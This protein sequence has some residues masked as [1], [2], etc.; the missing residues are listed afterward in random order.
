MSRKITT[1]IFSFKLVLHYNMYEDVIYFI[2]HKLKRA[3]LKMFLVLIQYKYAYNY[4]EYTFVQTF[5]SFL[6][7]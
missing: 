7:N 4:M 6:F 5:D 2:S 1:L 3:A